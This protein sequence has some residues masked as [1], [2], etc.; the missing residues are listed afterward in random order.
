MTVTVQIPLDI[1]DICLLAMEQ[2][3]RGEL[4][5]KVESLGMCQ[6]F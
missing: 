5:L 3:E 1:P 2:T 4:L 6:W